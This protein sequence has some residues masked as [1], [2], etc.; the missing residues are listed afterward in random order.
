MARIKRSNKRRMRR[1]KVLK[2]AKGYFLTKSKLHRQARLAV[3]RAMEMSFRHR[4][5]KKRDFRKLWILRINAGARANGLSYSRF[6]D[7]LNKAGVE[8]N[9]KMLSEMAIQDPPSFKLLV[10]KAQEAL[11]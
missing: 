5:T 10:E 2:Q 4:R 6:I 11:K 3:A 1:K 9:R 8:I 7:G